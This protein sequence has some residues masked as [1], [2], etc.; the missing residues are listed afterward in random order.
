M[1]TSPQT[2]M[3]SAVSLEDVA[4]SPVILGYFDGA[5]QSEAHEAVLETFLRMAEEEGI[6]RSFLARRLNKPREQIT[7]WLGAPGNWTL[8]TLTNLSLAMGHRPRISLERLSGIQQP[9]EHHPDASGVRITA[10]PQPATDDLSATPQER[11]V[12]R[13]EGSSVYAKVEMTANA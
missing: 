3:K 4:I 13:N 2:L 8:D 9:N 12:S 7:R 11:P 6:T 1:L 5:A 10:P